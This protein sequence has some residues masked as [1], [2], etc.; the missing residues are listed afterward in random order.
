MKRYLSLTAILFLVY[1]SGYGQETNIT[2]K[3]I[4]EIFSDFHVKINDTTSHTGF[5]LNRAY[6]GYQ[7]LPGGNISGKVIINIGSPEDLA[8]GSTPRRYAYCREASLTWSDDKLS[9]SMGITGTRIF[10][11]QQKFWGKRYIANTYQS[12]NGYGFIADLGI[13]A[14][15]VVNEYLSADFTLMNGEGYSNLQ[16]DD[17]LRSS[18]GLTITPNR[19]LAIR[20]YGDIQ[21][22]EGLWQPVF[23]GFAGFKNDR[24]T[25]GSEVSYKSNIDLIRGHHVW[26]LSTTGGINIT[27]KTE[28]FLRYDYMSSFKLEGEIQKWNYIKDGMLVITGFQYSFSQNIKIAVN[29]QGRYPYSTA[30]YSNDLIYLNTLFRF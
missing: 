27:E 11:Y 17:N 26:G 4:A 16:L 8:A 25:I 1:Y 2:G 9:V 3:P 28:F 10:A 19:N 14:E 15:Y 23:V 24:F 5:G 29:Y 22:M 13:A 21:C 30:G 7:F 20:F 12:I 18:L 6:L